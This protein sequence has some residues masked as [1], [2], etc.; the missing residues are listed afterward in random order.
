M[1]KKE[2]TIIIISHQER[3]IRLA[4]EIVLGG[5]WNGKGPWPR[6]ANLSENSRRYRL[7]LRPFGGEGYMLNEIQKKILQTVADMAAIPTGA[8]NIRS[9]GQKAYRHNSEHIRI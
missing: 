7:F 4:D 8:V 3:I 6:R 2:A 9:D 5:R 1:I